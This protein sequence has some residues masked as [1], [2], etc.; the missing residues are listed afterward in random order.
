VLNAAFSAS[1]LP[2]PLPEE[3]Q[4]AIE[5]YLDRHGNTEH[6]DSQKL[7]E[8]LLST[9]HKYIATKPEK[10]APFLRTLRLFLPAIPTDAVLLEWWEL[11]IRPSVDAVGQKNNIVDEAKALL[12]GILTYDAEDKHVEARATLSRQFLSIMLEIY[13]DRARTPT[14]DGI[15]TSLEDEYIAHDFESIFIDFGRRNPKVKSMR[16]ACLEMTLTSSRTSSLLL[17]V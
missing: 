13:L 3:L 14:A 1:S 10:H 7:H 4:T 5:T 12:L 6:D 9:F 17:I 2:I 11:I 15:A 16:I 8:E